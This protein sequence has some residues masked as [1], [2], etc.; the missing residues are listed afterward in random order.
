MKQQP[1]GH[2]SCRITLSKAA[3]AAFEVAANHEAKAAELRASAA[4]HEAEA[5]AAEA[6]A[7]ELRAAACA[8]ALL[9][10][11]AKVPG[12]SKTAKKKANR[13]ANRKKKAAESAIVP[14]TVSLAEAA[15]SAGRAM[16]SGKG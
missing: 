14:Q 10:E 7:A 12:Q 5:E 1:R 2:P 15:F 8:E 13:K 11:E 9:L 3:E 16:S 4:A 6:R